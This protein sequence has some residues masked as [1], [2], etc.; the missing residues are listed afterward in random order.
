MRFT[1][2]VRREAVGGF[3]RF[4]VDESTGT[5]GMSQIWQFC[6]R[7]VWRTGC[8]GLV[9]MT[10]HLHNE[11]QTTDNKQQTTNDKQQTTD[12]QTS[13][14]KPNQTKPNHPTKPP[15]TNNTQHTTHHTTHHTTQETYYQVPTNQQTNCQP[16]TNQLLT[17][18]NQLPTNNKQCLRQK[19]R[20][21]C[22]RVLQGVHTIKNAAPGDKGSFHT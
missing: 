12:S 18:S 1:W 19:L 8:E 2:L 4:V 7:A 6:W 9:Q 11:Q 13:Q 15:T 22:W 16:T 14:T 10:R 5:L 21:R 3:I 20:S 17:T